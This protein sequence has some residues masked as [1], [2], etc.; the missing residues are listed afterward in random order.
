MKEKDKIP[1]T[2]QGQAWKRAIENKKPNAGTPHDWEDFETMNGSI[3][4]GHNHNK[5]TDNWDKIF[6]KNKQLSEREIVLMDP[7]AASQRSDKKKKD[8]KE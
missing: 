2:L 7:L 8:K 3:Q 4:K 6:G 5:F 1:G